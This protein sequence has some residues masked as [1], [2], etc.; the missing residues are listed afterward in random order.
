MQ[1][2][3]LQIATI[4]NRLHNGYPKIFN[5]SRCFRGVSYA[6][7]QQF[8]YFFPLP[9]G[10]L[11]FRETTAGFVTISSPPG[12]LSKC[13]LGAW[14]KA[15]QAPAINIGTLTHRLQLMMSIEIIINPPPTAIHALWFLNTFPPYFFLI[16]YKAQPNV[17][18]WSQRTDF[19]F[20][21]QNRETD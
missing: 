8:L 16:T 14:T 19:I 15:R 20:L 21:F 5:V 13:V 17:K 11:E 7:L 10:H 2:V 12:V 1:T 6:F 18:R 9:H 3:D 4:I